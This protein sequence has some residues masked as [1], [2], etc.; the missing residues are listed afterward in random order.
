MRSIVQDIDPSMLQAANVQLVI[1]GC[2]DPAMLKYYK[3]EPN[4]IS[5]CHLLILF[6]SSNI[7]LSIPVVYGPNP[8]VV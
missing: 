1:I 4:T 8:G 7:P 5:C 3:C 2:G 6:C